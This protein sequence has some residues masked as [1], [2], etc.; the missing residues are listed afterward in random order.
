MLKLIVF[1]REFW[2]EKKEEFIPT[3]DQILSLEHSL[4]SI[5]K[6]ETKWHKPF[7]SENKKTNEELIDYIRCMTITQN[8]DSFTYKRLTKEN[9]D[10][11]E[12]YIDDP[13][14][15]TWFNDSR[16]G[17]KSSKKERITSELIY[18]WM[19][20]SEIPFE[21]ETWNLNRLMVLI[22]ICSIKNKPPKKQGKKE[23]MKNNTSLNAAR[24]NKIG[25]S[26]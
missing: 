25:T 24:R 9:M 15:A 11:I 5:S 8:V 20:A 26:G 17:Q 23:I 10:Q 22:R 12:K 6:W 14:T 4:I 13:A 19:I 16:E 21:C 3:K 1:G 7:I 2:D 18:Y